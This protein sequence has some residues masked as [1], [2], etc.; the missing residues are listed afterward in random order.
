[1]FYEVS[2]ALAWPTTYISFYVAGQG[3]SDNGLHLLFKFSMIA[4]DAAILISLS[5]FFLIIFI[6][7]HYL[8]IYLFFLK[9]KITLNDSVK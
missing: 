5:L 7:N 8:A 2:N 4:L 6:L 3:Y 9:K 1:M